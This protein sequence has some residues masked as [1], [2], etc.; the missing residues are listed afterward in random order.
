MIVCLTRFFCAVGSVKIIHE[1]F[2]S[3]NEVKKLLHYNILC[4]E[5]TS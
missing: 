5:A 2:E 1:V 4:G 3:I